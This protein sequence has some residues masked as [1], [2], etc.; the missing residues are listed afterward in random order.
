M[1]GFA[2]CSPSRSRLDTT[3]S[4][5]AP[6]TTTQAGVRDAPACCYHAVMSELSLR[7]AIKGSGPRRPLRPT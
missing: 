6:S 3:P 1:T 7:L 5:R 4:S 2:V